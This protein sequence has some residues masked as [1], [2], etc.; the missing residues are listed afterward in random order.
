MDARNRPSPAARPGERICPGEKYAI[1][2]PI[3]R[4][5][6]KN[7]FPK[8]LLCPFREESESEQM[9]SDARIDPKI[10]REGMIR[11]RFP[12][13]LNPYVARKMGLAIGQFRRAESPSAARVAV[14]HNVWP[15]APELA[16]ATLKGLAESGLDVVDLGPGTH[17]LLV[18]ALG[19]GGYDMGV[20]VGATDCA[21]DEV[22]LR[23]FRPDG[24]PVGVSNGL[25]AV[26]SIARRV[27]EAKVGMLG[28]MQ[29]R[30]VS[31]AYG[32]YIA[33]F[34]RHL[35][36]ARCVV[37]AGG[38]MAGRMVPLATEELPLDI[39]MLDT[40]LD[41]ERLAGYDPGAW[42]DPAAVEATAAAVRER[43][44]EFGVIFDPPMERAAFLDEQGTLRRPDHAAILTAREL[45]R[46]NA[47]GAVLYDVRASAALRDDVRGQGGRLLRSPAD[48]LV[49]RLTMRHKNVLFGVSAD[50][51]FFFRDF[52]HADSALVATLLLWS[53]LSA[54]DAP[55]SEVL[56]PL[57]RYVHSGERVYKVGSASDVRDAIS[58][59]KEELS[60]GRSDEL[61]G[62]TVAFHDWWVNARVD[63]ERG[64][65]RV[66]V[67]ARDEAVLAEA[68]ARVASVL[69]PQG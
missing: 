60:D 45:L 63:G 29:E 24:S 38:G 61:D 53:A 41:E 3:C 47:G 69:Q 14:T 49:M 68:L 20:L 4:S 31:D 40:D 18:F 56:A 26:G 51:H 67:E 66:N 65:V 54:A 42:P 7:R 25:D 6:Q 50:G 12:M 59:L 46:R 2:I 11:G 34:G 28:R 17:D 62:V 16:E 22:A 32:A 33:K 35:R 5:R 10:I 8:C 13:E 21:P 58:R 23:I 9:E 37:H 48:Y 44:A 1:S 27:G 19:S 57:V 30:D 15:S 52:F 55:M 64:A 39:S 43:G 36:P